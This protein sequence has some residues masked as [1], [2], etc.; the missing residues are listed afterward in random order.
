MWYIDDINILLTHLYDDPVQYV[1]ESCA[2]RLAA[3]AKEDQNITNI[4]LDELTY[5]D[6]PLIDKVLDEIG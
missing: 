3:L 2:N 4:L 6:D 1:R 5:S